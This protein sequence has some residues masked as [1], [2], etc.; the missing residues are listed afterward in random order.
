M[1][2]FMDFFGRT[3][4]TCERGLFCLHLP[5]THIPEGEIWR[6]A[7]SK[8]TVGVAGLW[9]MAAS[10]QSVWRLH[11]GFLPALIFHV[12]TLDSDE[13]KRGLW[14][15][16]G[17]ALSVS[18][19]VSNWRPQHE[20]NHQVRKRSFKLFLLGNTVCNFKRYSSNLKLEFCWT[21]Y[22][23]LSYLF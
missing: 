8:Q 13:V 14:K 10:C 12:K 4:P 1:C 23:W 9:S 20:T 5:W 15:A 21:F 19:A 16:R 11:R 22:E 6:W 3:E 2:E 18:K 7:N 17:V